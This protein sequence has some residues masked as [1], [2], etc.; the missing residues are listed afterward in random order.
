MR[1]HGFVVVPVEPVLWKRDMELW[2]KEK[3][4]SRQMALGLFPAMAKSIR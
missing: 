3:E 1:S 2:R 4:E